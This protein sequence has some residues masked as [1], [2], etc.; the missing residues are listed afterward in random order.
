[1]EKGY[2]I[3]IFKEDKRTKN[4]ERHV[5]VIDYPNV[6]ETTM[7]TTMQHLSKTEYRSKDGF[8]L[9]L[10]PMTKMVKNLMSGKM[11]EI[12]FRTPYYLDP[13]RETYWSR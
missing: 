3:L 12:D 7:L 13:S 5:K 10:E 11:V 2:R 9:A 4:G 6:N 8:R 1:M